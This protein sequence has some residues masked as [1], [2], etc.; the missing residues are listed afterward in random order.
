MTHGGTCWGWSW[1][2]LPCTIW[3]ITLPKIVGLGCNFDTIWG[4]IGVTSDGNLNCLPI[5]LLE[6]SR[7]ECVLTLCQ[8]CSHGCTIDTID[9]TEFENLNFGMF[10]LVWLGYT[11]M[12]PKNVRFIHQNTQKCNGLE[13]NQMVLKEPYMFPYFDRIACIINKTTGDG[14]ERNPRSPPFCRV[15]AVLSKNGWI[16]RGIWPNW[17]PTVG[18]TL[19]TTPHL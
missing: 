4:P 17:L 6:L 11:E 13:R 15:L 12:V 9:T 3:W 1:K 5:L 19:A 8:I 16:C 10:G 14:L 18:H 7:L 2:K